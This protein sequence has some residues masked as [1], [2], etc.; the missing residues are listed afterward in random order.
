MTTRQALTV[1]A[2]LAL[3]EE[4]PYLEYVRGEAVPKMAPDWMHFNLAKRILVAL[5]EYEAGFGGVAGV[6]GR[7]RFDDRADTRFLLPDVAYYAKGRPLRAGEFMAPPTLAVEIRSVGQSMNEQRDKCHYYREHGV[8]AVLLIDP[9]NRAVEA[10]EGADHRVLEPPE[11]VT[12]AALPGFSVSL[13]DL[14]SGLDAE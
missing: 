11:N 12:L 4:K 9:E 7:V 13:T 6:E 3:P 8:D 5:A 14:F 1:E 2:Y 10:F